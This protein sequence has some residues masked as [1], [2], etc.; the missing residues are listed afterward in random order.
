MEKVTQQMVGY[1]QTNEELEQKVRSMMERESGL[2][3]QLDAAQGTS[4]KMEGTLNKISA[5]LSQCS[6]FKANDAMSI[7]EGVAK[8][9]ESYEDITIQHSESKT[10][11]SDHEL[12]LKES[13]D[14]VKRLAVTVRK[15]Q[16]V[17]TKLQQSLEATQRKFSEVSTRSEQYHKSL[18][19]VH[20]ETRRSLEKWKSFMAELN[21]SSSDPN[22]KSTTPDVAM[23]GTVEREN[24]SD[25]EYLK[26]CLSDVRSVTMHFIQSGYAPR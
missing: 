25:G 6:F 17:R 14:K 2:R 8:L 24:E 12:K 22:T 11:A 23:E 5:S 16:G 10:T 26:R 13:E 18:Q 3:A 21:A 20:T 4:S 9:A 15:L 19:T 1:K 7:T